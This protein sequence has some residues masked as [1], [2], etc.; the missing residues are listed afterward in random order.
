MN[1]CKFG[2]VVMKMG[3]AT[4]KATNA[5]VRAHLQLAHVNL[6]LTGVAFAVLLLLL[7]LALPLALPLQLAIGI[8]ITS[9]ESIF[10]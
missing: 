5:A 2:D 4:I 7:P 1:I 8:E 3:P 6:R 10:A 9:I